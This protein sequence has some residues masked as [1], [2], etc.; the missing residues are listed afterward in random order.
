[1]ENMPSKKVEY[2]FIGITND[3]NK[4]FC[5]PDQ[6][7]VRFDYTEEQMVDRYIRRFKW[8]ECKLD[9]VD[10]KTELAKHIAYYKFQ[11]HLYN[12]LDTFPRV[13]LMVRAYLKVV[14]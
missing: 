13:S 1:M 10:R 3:Y 12:H 2:Y 5:A 14:N 4:H 6:I 11:E 7:G 9:E 8:V